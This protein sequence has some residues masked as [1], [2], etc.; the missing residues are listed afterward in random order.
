[1][2]KIVEERMIESEKLRARWPNRIPVSL[3]Q[4]LLSSRQSVKEIGKV[5]FHYW[6]NISIDVMES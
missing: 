2:Y 3:R 6:R 5:I 1:M 4:F